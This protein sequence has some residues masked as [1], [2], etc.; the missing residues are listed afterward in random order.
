MITSKASPFTS[1][2]ESHPLAVFSCFDE[3]QYDCLVNTF[4][5]IRKKERNLLHDGILSAFF[6]FFFL[7]VSLC[8]I[9]IC[10]LTFKGGHV[11]I[12]CYVDIISFLQSQAF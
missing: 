5:D 12:D 1:L 7:N 4:R 6:F 3:L 10:I 9:L 8:I 11:S 2:N